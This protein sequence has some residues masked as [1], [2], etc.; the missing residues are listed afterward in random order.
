MAQGEINSTAEHSRL[1][2][3]ELDSEFGKLLFII[4]IRSLHF[5]LIPCVMREFIAFLGVQ[6]AQPGLRSS[7]CLAIS[8]QVSSYLFFQIA[9]ISLSYQSLFSNMMS[10]TQA[11]SPL[12]QSL[13]SR[14]CFPS[15]PSF[16]STSLAISCTPRIFLAHLRKRK[17]ERHWRNT[18]NCG[19]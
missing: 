8:L 2:G 19:K 7:Y 6:N 10:T 4:T 15:L 18:T 13:W 5:Q 9:Y 14:V 17:R 16:T 3:G 1:H 12:A 11:H